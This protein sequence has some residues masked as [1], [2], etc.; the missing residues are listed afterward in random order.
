MKR[1]NKNDVKLYGESYQSARPSVNVKCYHFG[2]GLSETDFGCSE[3]TF[4]KAMEY[5][6]DSICQQFWDD[7]QEEAEYY[8]G[9]GV[10]VYS[11]G[12]SGGH[13]IVEGLSDVETWDAI[14]LTKW[15]RF[16]KAALDEVKYVSSAG[17]VKE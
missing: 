10:K 8:F 4:N 1:Y 12:H 9:K 5:A 14:E 2:T 13:L 16:E 15:Y 7:M 3:E 6:F 17:Y 11:A